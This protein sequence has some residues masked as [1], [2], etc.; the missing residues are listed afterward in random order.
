M[1]EATGQNR[2][3]SCRGSLVLHPKALFFLPYLS[4]QVTQVCSLNFF[5]A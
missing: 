1:I 3:S 4:I 2:E 5:L